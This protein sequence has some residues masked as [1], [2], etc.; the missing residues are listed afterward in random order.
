MA[1]QSEVTET[2][3]SVSLTQSADASLERDSSAFTTDTIPSDQ[4]SSVTSAASNA[5]VGAT[6]GAASAAGAAA[7]SVAGAAASAAV[8][9]TTTIGG[10]IGA[11]AGAV[12]SSVAVAVM[13]VAVF[14]STL[15]MNLSLVL[16]D[17]DTL[18]V[19]VEMQGAQEED[20]ESRIYATISGEDGVYYE[21]EVSADTVLL[22]FGELASDREYFVCIRNEEKIF[23]EKSF[24]TAKERVDK[25]QVFAFVEEGEV[26]IIVEDV[27]LK[28][29]EFYTVLV[30]DEDGKKLFGAD[31]S[32]TNGEY[33]FLLPEPK[34]LYI[35]LSVGDE[36]YAYYQVEAEPE[37]EPVTEYDFDHPIWNWAED[38]SAATLSFV[39]IHGGESL[40]LNAAISIE[41]SAQP[42]CETDGEKIYT[43]SVDYGD[44]S[45][46]DSQSIVLAAFGHTY[47]APVFTWTPI[48]SSDLS[49]AEEEP[50]IVTDDPAGTP[51]GYTATA[52]FTCIHDSSHSFDLVADVTSDETS[53]TCEADGEILYTATVIYDDTEY[54]DTMPVT[55]PALGHEY[56]VP[57]FT[58][59][60]IYESDNSG[61]TTEPVLSDGP[62]ETPI[63]YTAT[64]TFTCIHD[65]SHTFDLVAEV[66]STETDP[67]CTEDGEI[68]Y[69]ATVVYDAIEYY[70]T[71]P[72]TIPAL[73]HA[74]GIPSFAWTPV[75]SGDD[76][77]DAAPTPVG[78]TATA[79]FT[80]LRDGSHTLELDADVTYATTAATCTEDGYRTYTAS[81]SYGGSIYNDEYVYVF[82]GSAT[83][84]D[85]SQYNSDSDL[86]PT[87]T[88]TE[89][90]G[91]DY[92]AT[93]TFYCN[94]DPTHTEVFDCEIS[95]ED[96]SDCENGGT[97]YYYASIVFNDY[98]YQA[99]I[100]V[101]VEPGHHY[102]PV[103]H[104][105]IVDTNY[106]VELN[107]VCEKEDDCI[108]PITAEVTS[109]D[110][111][112][113]TLYTATATYNDVEYTETKKVA[114]ET[115]EKALA[116][117]EEYYVGD[118]MEIGNTTTF[119]TDD[120]A[121]GAHR[122]DMSGDTALLNALAAGNDGGAS[123]SYNDILDYDRIVID[124]EQYA[125]MEDG[126]MG[127]YHGSSEEASWRF[128]PGEGTLIGLT[129]TSGSGTQSDPYVLAP[130]YGVSVTYHAN[131]GI[132]NTI[133][134]Y[135][136][137][138]YYSED[139]VAD[140]VYAIPIAENPEA[141][142]RLFLGWFTD[143]YGQNA[144]DFE[145]TPI[146]GDLDLYA[147]W[148][149]V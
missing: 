36:I 58:W 40:V 78:Y 121:G 95:C 41:L 13:V 43:A 111:G 108:G 91:G 109:S 141:S 99:E 88:W 75:Y 135:E 138:Q 35:T 130:I 81:I 120:Y 8:S 98:D 107:M 79:T 48:Y 51:I 112:T 49:G 22:T 125:R 117:G 30:K 9:V 132:F 90:E 3:E 31:S 70:D 140:G 28:S 129:V 64:A 128:T 16:A 69:T 113:Y 25:G 57:V 42:T 77:G 55:I 84:H 2:S 100:E 62:E 89:G 147:G 137:T 45:F 47:G 116:I 73:G 93:A 146:T 110:E 10:T 72:V 145:H 124:N 133:E 33:V 123:L 50:E 20:F 122:T 19:K 39:E 4:L 94:N 143:E 23:V 44:R 114:N 66:T 104:W 37:P 71:L 106:E 65:S 118:T 63:G 101:E 142:G 86:Q 144:F 21:Q 26:H 102:I 53:P 29:K 67:D 27:Y 76:P 12:A 92:T 127:G 6:T 5:A 56:G 134:G 87:F 82:E 7:G 126:D 11:I 97:K 34:N 59:T 24:F 32:E 14:I 115:H 105:M 68:L 149:A 60:P 80:C 74:Y 119:F 103:F 46:S 136:M 139:A 38:H 83:G 18:V 61:A 148:I 1:Q 85:Y 17:V 131:D 54:H 52:R 15:T 96:T